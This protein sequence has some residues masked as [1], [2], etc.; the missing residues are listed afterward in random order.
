MQVNLQNLRIN[1]GFILKQNPAIIEKIEQAFSIFIYKI[2]GSK[3]S[4]N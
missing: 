1:F 4:L 2:V 3:Y